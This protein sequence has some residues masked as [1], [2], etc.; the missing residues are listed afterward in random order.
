MLLLP[1]TPPCN[2]AKP[3]VSGQERDKSRFEPRTSFSPSDQLVAAAADTYAHER[4]H[5][6]SPTAQ[7]LR[8]YE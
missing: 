2:T 3:L 7:Y 4:V 5:I 6:T 1:V 8:V